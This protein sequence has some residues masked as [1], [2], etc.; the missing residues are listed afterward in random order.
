MN[1]MQCQLKGEIKQLATYYGCEVFSID[2][3]T[4]DVWEIVVVFAR[5]DGLKR[6]ETMKINGQDLANSWTSGLT[7]MNAVK[8]LFD[9]TE[10]MSKADLSR[11]RWQGAMMHKYG[12]RYLASSLADGRC[13]M[14][15]NAEQQIRLSE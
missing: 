13:V 7:R 1:A 5:A 4:G 15:G 12:D 10:L 8:A 6:V 11:R 14:V 2:I 9:D 3:K